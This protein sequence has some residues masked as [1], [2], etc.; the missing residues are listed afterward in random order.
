MFTAA[1]FTIAEIQKQPK[2]LSVHGRIKIVWYIYTMKY[3][4]TMRKQDI[5]PF[6]TA[7]V[8]LEHILLSG[9]T[10]AEKDKYCV[11]SLTCEI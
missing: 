11:I 7:R 1:L 2:C 6:A 3:Y 4:S 5:L 10:Q 8:D 9:I